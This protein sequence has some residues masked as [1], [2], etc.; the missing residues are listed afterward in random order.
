MSLP[1][2]LPLLV[3]SNEAIG[4]STLLAAAVELIPACP[5]HA[6]CY[7]VLKTAAN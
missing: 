6:L 7:V 2:P 5:P 1:L 4:P 3:I